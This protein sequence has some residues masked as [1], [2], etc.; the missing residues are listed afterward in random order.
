MRL[1]RGW[2][3]GVRR[4][5]SEALGSIGPAAAEAAPA[6]A[7]LLNDRNRTVR[8]AALNALQRIG[9][10]AAQVVPDLA[11]LFSRQRDVAHWQVTVE[12]MA[13]IKSPQ[14][15]AWLASLLMAGHEASRLAA[16]VLG[17]LGPVAAEAVPGLAKLLDDW[18]NAVRREARRAANNIGHKTNVVYLNMSVFSDVIVETQEKIPSI[19]DLINNVTSPD[20][21]VRWYSAEALGRIGPTASEAVPALAE[22]LWDQNPTVQWVAA[23]ALGRIGPLAREAASGLSRKLWDENEIVRRYAAEALGRIGPV[24]VEI[25]EKVVENLTVLLDDPDEIVRLRAPKP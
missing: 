14:T 21:V 17:R 15:A 9:P 8:R 10:G 3:A 20:A 18:E 13:S 6:L 19:S 24:P 2:N 7:M 23:E 22:L 25:V 16:E 11:E 5:A 1:L 12:T 4:A